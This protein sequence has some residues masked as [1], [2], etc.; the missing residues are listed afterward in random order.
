MNPTPAS[1]ARCTVGSETSPVMKTSAPPSMAWASML[2]AAPVHHA[3]R[4][5]GMKGSPMTSGALPSRAWICAAIAPSVV[6]PG[7]EPLQ[8]RLPGRAR[9]ALSSVKAASGC[10]PSTRASCALLPRVGWASSGKWYAIR[11]I[12]CASRLA[13][14]F[15]RVPSTRGSSP[16]HIQPWC[17]SNA[18]AP[19]VMAS[20]MSAWLAVTPAI[21]WLVV[22]LPS[23]CNPLGQ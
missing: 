14:R 17:T 7:I 6:A 5:A 1:R 2:C 12:S 15:L 19:R 23:T 8:I 21:I 3:M 11:L 13:R 4:A 16:F 22:G 10:S 20:S 9:A 18:S